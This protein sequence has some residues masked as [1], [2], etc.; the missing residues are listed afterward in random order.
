MTIHDNAT[1]YGLLD[2]LRAYDT[3]NATEWENLFTEE[4]NELDSTGSGFISFREINNF[5]TMTGI[6]NETSFSDDT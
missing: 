3:E 1:L 5:R 6:Q 4:F 2:L